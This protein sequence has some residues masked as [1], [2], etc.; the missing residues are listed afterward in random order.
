M[1]RKQRKKKYIFVFCP[2]VWKMEIQALC[3]K[4]HSNLQAGQPNLLCQA[5]L[6]GELPT[7][8][9]R[10]MVFQPKFPRPCC[11]WPRRHRK[12]RRLIMRQVYTCQS[13]ACD[14]QKSANLMNRFLK[15]TLRPILENV[16]VGKYWRLV[17]HLQICLWIGKKAVR[18]RR[19]KRANKPLLWFRRV[20]SWKVK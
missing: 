14:A 17:G 13:N 19:L 10:A 3:N 15:I 1:T 2:Y 4:G 20:A 9:I 5:R 12:S 16:T 7:S 6:T 11:L 8:L 18:G